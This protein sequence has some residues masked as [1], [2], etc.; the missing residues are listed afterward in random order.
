M[1][2]KGV[3]RVDEYELYHYGVPGM[4]WGVRRYQKKDQ[5]RKRLAA[6]LSERYKETKRAAKIAG[7][8]VEENKQLA[9]KEKDKNKRKFYTDDAEQYAKLVSEYKAAGKLYIEANKKLMSLDV[10]SVSK[11]DIKK[12]Y[13][14][15]SSDGWKLESFPAY[16]FLTD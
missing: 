15:A 7:G 3:G 11:R 8:I 16:E 6:S 2:A 9:S 5:L 12:I 1:K 14:K 4:K 13:K 10:N